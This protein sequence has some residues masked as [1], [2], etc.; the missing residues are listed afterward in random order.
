MLSIYYLATVVYSKT[1]EM[2][3]QKFEPFMHAYAVLPVLVCASIG[4]SKSYFFSQSGQCWIA[5]PCLYSKECDGWDGLGKGGWL[6]IASMIWVVINSL[7][8]LYCM[9]IIYYQINNRARAMRRYSVSQASPPVPGRME[10]AANDTAIQGLLYMS[11]FLLTYSWA[12]IIALSEFINGEGSSHMLFIL[13]AVFL[14][15]QGFWNFL[16]YIRPR[17]VKLRRGHLSLS[18]FSTLKTIIFFAEDP[19]L[20]RPKRQKRWRNR[21]FEPDDDA[22]EISDDNDD[23]DDAPLEDILDV[24]EKAID[25]PE[26]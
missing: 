23:D 10:V 12:V 14:P 13:T 15:L 26:N 7:V 16:A 8:T 9:V 22:I 11:A 2:I 24:C 3:A 19:S 18:F 25:S 17:F 6:A 1:E 4:A 5:D 21:R 20:N